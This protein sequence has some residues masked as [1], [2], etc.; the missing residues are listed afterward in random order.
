MIGSVVLVSH[1]QLDIVS[2]VSPMSKLEI[3]WCNPNPVQHER[4][5]QPMSSSNHSLY[6]VEEFVSEGE[7]GYWATKYSLEVVGGG[8]A[9]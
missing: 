8:C 6:I 7:K 1:L 2:E 4:R 3:V 9:A 5:W